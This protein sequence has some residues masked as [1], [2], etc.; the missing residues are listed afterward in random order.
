MEHRVGTARRASTLYN[1]IESD[2]DQVD[3]S[4]A[5]MGNINREASGFSTGLSVRM[6][7][8][9]VLDTEQQQYCKELVLASPG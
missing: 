5:A 2:K 8:R 6:A 9:A 3:L 7:G 1:R 4:L